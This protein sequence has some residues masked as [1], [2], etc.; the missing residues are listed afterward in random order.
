MQVVH[1]GDQRPV[2]APVE[3]G[4]APLGSELECLARLYSKRECKQRRR[5]GRRDSELVGGRRIGNQ[6][7]QVRRGGQWVGSTACGEGPV[8]QG[9]PPISEFP[10]EPGLAPSG[11]SGLGRAFSGLIMASLLVGNTDVPSTA[12]VSLRFH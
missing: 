2:G 11:H 1:S 10:P 12:E 6:Q 3:H 5:W 9:L 8:L 4:L 7:N